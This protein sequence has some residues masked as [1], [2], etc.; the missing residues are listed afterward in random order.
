MA[1]NVRHLLINISIPLRIHW[2]PGMFTY[3]DPISLAA[4]HVGKYSSH[5][6]PSWELD[7]PRCLASAAF[8]TRAA[9]GKKQQDKHHL[10]KPKISAKFL[11]QKQ[12]LLSLD[13]QIPYWA[14]ILTPKNIPNIHSEEV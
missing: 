9:L 14:N 8:G 6:D 7:P 3:I 11:K 1:Y 5:M 2:L 13:I 4:I 10:K 12:H